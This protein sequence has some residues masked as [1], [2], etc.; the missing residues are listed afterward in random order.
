MGIILAC[1][2]FLSDEAGA[3]LM[4]FAFVAWSLTVGLTP[5]RLRW[6]PDL[7]ERVARALGAGD[8]IGRSEGIRVGLGRATQRDVYRALLAAGCAVGVIALS[9]LAARGAAIFLP[10]VPVLIAAGVAGALAAFLV[11]PF[12]MVSGVAFRR[13]LSRGVHEAA[14]APRRLARGSRERKATWAVTGTI[15]GVALTLALCALIA[16]ELAPRVERPALLVGS[17]L[18]AAAIAARPK[19]LLAT[20]ERCERLVGRERA[21]E[22]RMHDFRGVQPSGIDVEGLV[23]RAGTRP[24]WSPLDKLDLRPQTGASVVAVLRGGARDPQPLSPGMVVHPGDELVLAG[25]PGQLVAA[26]RYLLSPA[27]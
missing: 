11:L 14:M 15:A 27:V 18:G 6:G 12:S 26:R 5:L 24:A 20:V 3:R 4:A 10:P 22:T 1:T 21:V 16:Y 2:P 25:T 19:L 13:A 23:V 7:A 9:T 8:R 17:L